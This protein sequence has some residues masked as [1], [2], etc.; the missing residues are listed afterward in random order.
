MSKV[1]ESSC[2]LYYTSKAAA[3][4]IDNPASKWPTAGN[5]IAR[6]N[7][8]GKR[9]PWFASNWTLAT[10]ARGRSD[11]PEVRRHQTE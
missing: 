11:S 1:F 10:S 5:S 7:D 2:V 9:A 8:I 4:E 3:G 6:I